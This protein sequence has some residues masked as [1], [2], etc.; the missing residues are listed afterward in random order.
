MPREL[1]WEAV[2]IM[3]FRSHLIRNGFKL[4]ILFV[5]AFWIVTLPEPDPDSILHYR[6]AV[7]V[8]ISLLKAGMILY[9][10][11]FYDRYA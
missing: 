7:V 11:L 10:T 6:N 9:D 4:L 3:S 8:L 1:S 5:A 2:Q